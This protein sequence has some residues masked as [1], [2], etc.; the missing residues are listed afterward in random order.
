MIEGHYISWREVKE[1]PWTNFRPE[2]MA[3]RGSGELLV[4]P[5]FISRLQTLR[6]ILGKP[7][8]ITS[9]FRTPEYNER[10]GGAK[11]SAHV[12]GRAA[13]IAVSGSD[14][15]VLVRY[16]IGVGFTG[17][18]VKQHGADRFVHVDDVEDWNI[19]PALWSYA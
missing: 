9:G 3:C 13:D 16:A 2:E 4:V 5:S 7:I 10:V 6:H 12:K 15:F 14:A 18:G 8:R 19:R 17:I 1:W 11:D